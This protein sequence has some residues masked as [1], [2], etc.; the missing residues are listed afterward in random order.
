M[1]LPEI[2]LQIRQGERPYDV[3]DMRGM[4]TCGHWSA[5]TFGASSTRSA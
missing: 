3:P 2:L 4:L 5:W 1:M